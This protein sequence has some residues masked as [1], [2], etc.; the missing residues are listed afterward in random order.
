MSTAV[1]PLVWLVLAGS[2][3]LLE[4]LASGFSMVF[5]WVP[6]EYWLCL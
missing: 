3:L 6:P 4:M 1:L 5:W 2:L